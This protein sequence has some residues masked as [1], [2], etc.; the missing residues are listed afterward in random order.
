[1]YFTR[2][3]VSE[4]RRLRVVVRLVFVVT[5]SRRGIT[6]NLSLHGGL[7]SLCNPSRQSVKGKNN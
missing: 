3:N 1:M 7:G 2:N 5:V 4:I 6:H